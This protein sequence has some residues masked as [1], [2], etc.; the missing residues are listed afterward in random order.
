MNLAILHIAVGLCSLTWWGCSNE[1]AQEQLN[2]DVQRLVLDYER[3]DKDIQRYHNERERLV[4][5]LGQLILSSVLEANIGL[6][7][8]NETAS[9][10][11]AEQQFVPEAERLY[12][13]GH[14]IALELTYLYQQRDSLVS[15]EERL[16]KEWKELSQDKEEIYQ[17]VEFIKEEYLQLSKDYLDNLKQ[18]NIEIEEQSKICGEILDEVHQ[19]ERIRKEALAKIDQ[20]KIDYEA[21]DFKFRFTEERLFAKWT[22]AIDEEK[23]MA[24]KHRRAISNLDKAAQIRDQKLNYAM[25]LEAAYEQAS[26]RL[27]QDIERAYLNWNWIEPYLNR[28]VRAVE[29]RP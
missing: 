17:T 15:K 5:R 16:Y 2:R 21:H 28:L 14:R 25:Q 26:R 24:K 10:V 19:I 9:I 11:D 29:N 1:K 3:F 27:E 18:A 12:E 23:K 6:T 4:Q 20:A 7:I 22:Q 13:E 8:Q